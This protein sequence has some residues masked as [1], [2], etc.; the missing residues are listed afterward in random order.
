MG[1][2]P[3]L[4]ASSEPK[5]SDRTGKEFWDKWWEKSRL[6]PPI[7]P[8]R[9]GLKNYP[10]RR[11]HKYFQKAFEGH[12]TQGKKLIEIGCAQSTFLPYFAK[13][14]GFEVH[15]IDRSEL[16]CERARTILE[17]EKVS[18][19]VH[20]SDFFSPPEHLIGQFDVVF[21]QGV[22]EHFEQTAEAVKAIARLLKVEGKMITNIPN[23]TGP[24]RAYQ[25]V[26]DKGIYDVQVPLNRESLAAAHQDA[27]LRVERCEYF[28][29]ISLEVLNVASWRRGFPYWF[30]I[31]THGV[32]SRLVWL[33]DDHLVSL[34][35]NRLTSPYVNCIA[36]RPPA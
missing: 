5:G 27:G 1:S 10:V 20:C 32:I 7:D 6:P 12:P 14:F 17:N 2:P 16:G 24:L 25:K 19:Q 34:G 18:G 36:R 11:F 13:Y 26:L 28:L 15:G 22:V 8:L 21:S 30:T 23:F 33:V 29:P 9:A 35:P 31:R 3:T 4:P